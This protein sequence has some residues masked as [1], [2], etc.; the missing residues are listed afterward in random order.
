MSRGGICADHFNPESFT[1]DS[2]TSLRHD[3]VPMPYSSTETQTEGSTNRTINRKLVDSHEA[4]KVPRPLIQ[5][6]EDP[7]SASKKEI[8]VRTHLTDA[9]KTLRKVK[10]IKIEKQCSNSNKP[11][12][13]ERCKNPET[14]PASRQINDS[15]SK[16]RPHFHKVFINKAEISQEAEETD[17]RVLEGLKE[18]CKSVAISTVL[19]EKAPEVS[20]DKMYLTERYLINITKPG[21]KKDISCTMTYGQ[22]AFGENSQ[23]LRSKMLG[24]LGVSVT[25]NEEGEKCEQA[26]IRVPEHIQKKYVYF[27]LLV[28]II[29]VAILSCMQSYKS[30]EG[31][32]K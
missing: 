25:D 27:S 14:C 13:L 1:D 31:S 23:K 16:A 4:Q 28:E 5:R 8:P 30:P 18:S 3:A 11:M 6:C 19:D 32:P 26:K 9:V 10:M 12:V 2:R 15:D 21:V 24:L 17:E 29:I 20:S 7:V 22:K